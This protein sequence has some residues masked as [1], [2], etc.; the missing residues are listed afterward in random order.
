MACL[1]PSAG[2]LRNSYGQ[3]LPYR[4]ISYGPIAFYR[5]EEK[6]MVALLPALGALVLTGLFVAYEW[7]RGRIQQQRA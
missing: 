4:S 6:V 7:L 3:P 1:P 2:I 5:I